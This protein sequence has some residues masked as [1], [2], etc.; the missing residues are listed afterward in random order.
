[1]DSNSKITEADNPTVPARARKAQLGV[2]YGDHNRDEFRYRLKQQIEDGE[3][4]TFIREVNHLVGEGESPYADQV[5][6]YIRAVLGRMSKATT[7]KPHPEM[8]IFLSDTAGPFA[9]IITETGKHPPILIIG[10]GLID[11]IVANG[12]GE[13]HF[14]AILGHER[15]HLLRHKRWEGLDNGR[16]E[17]TVGDIYGIMEANRAGYNPQALGEF[18]RYLKSKHDSDAPR[19]IHTLLE[20][21]DE[22]PSLSD[23]VRNCELAMAHLQLTRRLSEQTTPIPVDI[24]EASWGVQYTS[25][26]D[27][28]KSEHGYARGSLPPLLPPIGGNSPR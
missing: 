6:G 9:G 16:P 21:M 19:P 25:T 24:V 1:M 7:S 15:F 13:D 18:F 27:Q 5:I 28:Y 20:L 11:Q 22:H 2:E 10:L 3:I 8:R 26:Y 12:F 14:A 4:P 23:R 17:E